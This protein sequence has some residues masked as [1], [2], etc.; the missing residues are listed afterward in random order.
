MCEKKV[1]FATHQ[2][3]YRRLEGNCFFFNDIF[4]IWVEV[5]HQVGVETF[6]AATRTEHDAL[7]NVALVAYKI[8]RFIPHLVRDI[9]SYLIGIQRSFPK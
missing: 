3:I 5:I 9:F 1:A 7:P 4:P 8:N 6:P 2:P